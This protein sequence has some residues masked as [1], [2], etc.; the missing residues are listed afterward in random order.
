MSE[1]LSDLLD[2][3]TAV[4]RTRA[5]NTLSPMFAHGKAGGWDAWERV[6]AAEHVLLFETPNDVIGDGGFSVRL[7]RWV[8]ARLV[9]RMQLL[10]PRSDAHYD[11]RQEDD[12][13]SFHDRWGDESGTRVTA[14]SQAPTG[15]QSVAQDDTE[16]SLLLMMCALLPAP[17]DR[18][19]LDYAEGGYD[20]V[21][22]NHRV[23]LRGAQKKVRQASDLARKR[24]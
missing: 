3:S 10:F 16:Q 2:E 14:P 18:V 24:M 1:Y 11:L 9:R 8:S 19:L 22:S 7:H 4:Q 17:H 15:H 21:M 6:Y 12:A 13:E 5:V 20:L 23:Q